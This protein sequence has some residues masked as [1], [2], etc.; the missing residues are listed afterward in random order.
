MEVQSTHVLERTSPFGEPFIGKCVLCGAKNLT[1]N[2]SN[3]HCDNPCGIPAEVALAEAV[4]PPSPRALHPTIRGFLLFLVEQPRQLSVL[5]GGDVNATCPIYG[6]RPRGWT[7]IDEKEAARA[8][9]YGD[10]LRAALLSGSGLCIQ[11]RAREILAYFESS[12]A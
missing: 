10:E 6:G 9:N 1:M 8:G 3:D 11:C 12:E 7:C 2:Q 5:G 4:S